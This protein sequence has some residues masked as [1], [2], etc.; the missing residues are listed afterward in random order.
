MLLIDPDGGFA[1]GP[2]PKNLF[3]DRFL[4]HGPLIWFETDD[5]IREARIFD[6]SLHG[7]NGLKK[8]AN[9]ADTAGTG[10]AFVPSGKAFSVALK[11]FS[12]VVDTAFDFKEKSFTE[13]TLNLGVTIVDE[14]FN[15]K[16]IGKFTKNLPDNFKKKIIEG[17]AG[18]VLSKGGD[19][20]KENVTPGL[21]K[22]IDDSLNINN[23]KKNE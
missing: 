22:S 10:F 3:S 4:K 7:E 2:D 8:V 17:V 6:N 21:A 13:A 1:L 16:F 14:V 19:Y 15:P 12:T 11:A 9:G 20:L 18:E 23:T 5:Q